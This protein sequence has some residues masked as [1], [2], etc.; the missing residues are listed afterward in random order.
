MELHI[1]PYRTDVLQGPE[2]NHKQLFITSFKLFKLRL[3]ESRFTNVAHMCAMFTGCNVDEQQDYR[4]QNNYKQIQLTN[5][6]C[7]IGIT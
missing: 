7:L 4:T 6:E 3:I 1:I 2:G 5:Q